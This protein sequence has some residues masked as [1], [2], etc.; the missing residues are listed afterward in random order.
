MKKLLLPGKYREFPSKPPLP[1]AP[2]PRNGVSGT[3]SLQSKQGI[4][5]ANRESRRG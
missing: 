2:S 3:N 4:F 1:P 5:I